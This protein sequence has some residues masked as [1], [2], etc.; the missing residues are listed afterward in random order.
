MAF[1]LSTL[2]DY[3]WSDIK[4]AAKNAMVTAALGGGEL[5]IRRAKSRADQH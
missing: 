5:E 2:T 1:D 3:A 4:V